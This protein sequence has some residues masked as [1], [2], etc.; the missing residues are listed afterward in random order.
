MCMCYVIFAEA[1]VPS[2]PNYLSPCEGVSCPVYIDTNRDMIGCIYTVE[3]TLRDCGC[4]RPPNFIFNRGSHYV[5]SPRH[6]A[7][8]SCCEDKSISFF[9]T[10]RRGIAT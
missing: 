4:G 8:M 3:G 7:S 2:I 9:A 10:V 5:M 6:N 1:L